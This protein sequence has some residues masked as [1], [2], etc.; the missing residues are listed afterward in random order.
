VFA[1]IAVGA[2]LTTTGRVRDQETLRRLLVEF[3]RSRWPGRLD[4][5]VRVLV[6][7]RPPPCRRRSV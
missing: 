5:L 7:P 1:L 3:K 4:P 6:K 2:E